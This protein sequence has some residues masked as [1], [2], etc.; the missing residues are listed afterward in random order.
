[1]CTTARPAAVF[2]ILIFCLALFLIGCGSS[3][4]H[5]CNVAPVCCGPAAACP[6]PPQHLFAQ[7]GVAG[8]HAGSASDVESAI[9]ADALLTDEEKRALLAVYRS[10]VAGRAATS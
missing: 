6:A 3:T 5:V 7:A 10:Y 2:P 4:T 9:N 1:M 8:E